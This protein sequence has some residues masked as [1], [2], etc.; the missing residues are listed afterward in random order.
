VPTNEQRR[1]A[2]KRKLER[3]LANRASRAKRRRMITVI[4]SVV[5]VVVVVGGIY[6]L[7]TTG[8]GSPT[9]AAASSST[10][11]SSPPTTT[12]APGVPTN[13]PCKY[14]TTPS[15]PAPTGKNVGVP[16]DPNPTPKTGT[17]VVTLHTNFGDLPL[18]LDRA[19]APCTVQSILHL[20]STKYF[21]NT[22]CHRETAYPSLKV[23]QCGDPTGQ[24]TGG[25]G[26]NIPDENPTGLKAAPP[27]AGST[28]SAS[29]Y[30]RGVIA[31]ANT[32]QPNSGGSQFFLVYGD[33]QLPPKYAVFGTISTAGLATLDKI[34][35]NGITPGSDPSTGQPTPQDGM[36]K[37]TVTIQQ[38]QAS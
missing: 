19:Q 35:A 34:V 24:G 9:A 21:D 7:V 13:G 4:S 32:G 36:P 27:T 29:I 17:V 15:Q 6:L 28:G 12:A 1:Q 30:P 22:P 14:T 18:N 38:A 5:A 3:Q 33:S 37:Q 25:P 11:T 16:Q 26:Y 31:M 23:L 2:A 20:A 8:Q 10:T